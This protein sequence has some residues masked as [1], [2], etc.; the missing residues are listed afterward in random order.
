MLYRNFFEI[1]LGFNPTIVAD[2]TLQFKDEG[3]LTRDCD[4]YITDTFTIPD[5]VANVIPVAVLDMPTKINSCS[6]LPISIRKAEG[7]AN[8]DVTSI[9]YSCDSVVPLDVVDAPT[10]GDLD[11]T[12]AAV[13]SFFSGVEAMDVIVNGGTLLANADY[14]FSVILVN[15]FNEEWEESMIVTTSTDVTPLIEILGAEGDVVMKTD[16]TK[17]FRGIVSLKNCDGDLIPLDTLTY[18]WTQEAPI[19]ESVTIDDFISPGA[20]KLIIPRFSLQAGNDYHFRLTVGDDPANAVYKDFKV[21]V[22]HSEVRILN[23]KN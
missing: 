4:A 20:R 13:N 17:S 18:Q 11:V 19:T 6:D 12:L 8:R 14:E 16:E 10:Q 7:L 2:D 23:I 9:T 15:A 3:I 5:D 22:I 1:W 21:E